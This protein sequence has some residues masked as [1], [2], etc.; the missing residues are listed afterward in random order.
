M[1][2][3]DYPTSH[4]EESEND[5]K[6]LGAF[7]TDA[8]IADFLAWW[9]IRS[10]SDTVL[11]PC[12]GGGVFLRSACKRL[13]ELRGQPESQAF[14]VEIAPEV[15]QLIRDKLTEEYGLNGRNLRLADFFSIEPTDE[16]QVDAV[17][18]NPP[19]IRY[20]RFTGD[21]RKLGLACS[22]AQGVRLPELCSSWAP[23]I[24]HCV[25]MLRPGGRLAMILPM[26]VGHAKY[27]RP[28]LEH[29]RRSFGI[30]TFLTFR[31]KLFPELSEDTL[32]LLADEKGA[33]SSKFLSR[34]LAHPGQLSAIRETDQ[35]TL[36]GTREIDAAQI[37]SGESRLIEHFIPPKARDLYRELKA[38][39][40]AQ[41]LGTLANVGIGYVTGAN[42]FFHLDPDEAR[43]RRIPEEFL[44]PA[45][46][47]GRALSGLRFTPEDW[48][49]AVQTKE[50]GYLL[51]ISKD[52]RL[53]KSVRDY[54]DQ[55]EAKGIEKAYKCRTRSPWYS[56][57]HVYRPDAFLTYMSGLTPRL[58]ANDA[59]AFAPN[60]LHV[61]R[62]HAGPELTSDFVAALWQTS[63]TRL[64]VEIEGHALGGG[65]LKLEPTEAENVLVANPDTSQAS[66]LTG[67]AEE[68][69]EAVRKDGEEAAQER[70]D[71]VILREMLGL[72]S[73]DCEL[74]RSAANTLRARR[75]YQDSTNGTT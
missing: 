63:L 51:H 24:V 18:G 62:L 50:A 28:V 57:P 61:L 35:W 11:D 42:D 33:S 20:Q 72:T 73:T 74:L 5:A 45:I 58:V 7:Y 2:L 67:L 55:G 69:D 59:G 30:A 65:M 13:V 47:R 44:K 71:S 12:F 34:D 70:A 27:A 43:Q 15:H 19:F 6:T 39:T 21:A 56:V 53:P 75:G 36:S 8:Q 16:K 68:L 38:S 25:A 64:S 3:F 60:S 29:I 22:L 10:A 37:A 26:E 31:K 41:R 54:L 52:S 1:S 14:G 23:F 4:P 46:R 66:D 17:I 40:K 32:L 9:A 48:R 49:R